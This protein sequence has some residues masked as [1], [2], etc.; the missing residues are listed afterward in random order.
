MIMDR[1]AFVAVLLLLPVFCFAWGGEGHQLVALIAEDQLTPKTK[2][3]IA[4]LLDGAHISDAEVASW[5][6]EV[7]R[8]RRETG[9]W[10]YVD[11]PVTADKLDRARDGK[12]GNE[13]PNAT[14]TR[15]A[16]R[17]WSSIPVPARR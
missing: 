11:I 3:A 9:P 13:V 17:V 7:R 10:H 1:R 16:I 2:A 4:D 15:A 8:Q 14:R 5:A 6:D 12:G